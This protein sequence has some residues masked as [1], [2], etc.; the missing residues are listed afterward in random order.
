MDWNLG[1]HSSQRI[2][3]LMYEFKNYQL[4]GSSIKL[5]TY[6]MQ[7]IKRAGHSPSFCLIENSEFYSLPA[8]W[9]HWQN[10]GV[11]ISIQ[12]GGTNWRAGAVLREAFAM[13][14]IRLDTP[15]MSG[16]WNAL[17]ILLDFFMKVPQLISITTLPKLNV[18]STVN[19]CQEQL[20]SKINIRWCIDGF[21]SII[22]FAI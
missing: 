20:G 11:G 18:E 16:Y 14:W 13:E 10:S 9:V 8:V 22:T 15:W 19:H 1:F 2:N 3:T 6:N 12:K 4:K 5:W 17:E 21:S 7:S